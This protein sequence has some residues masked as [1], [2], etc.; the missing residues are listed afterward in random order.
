MC[1]SVREYGVGKSIVGGNLDKAEF[2]RAFDLQKTHD[3]ARIRISCVSRV[4]KE[5]KVRSKFN[6][7]SP[8]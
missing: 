6:D 5:L 4:F 1:P 2:A 3:C 7:S 8:E